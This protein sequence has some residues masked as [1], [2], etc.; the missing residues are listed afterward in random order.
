MSAS[1]F[2]TTNRRG[3][4]GAL[5][6]LGLQQLF[7]T[8]LV[9]QAPSPSDAW[10]DRMNGQHK[11][12]FDVPE[13]D[14][15]TALRH[16]HGYLDTWREAYGVAERDVN[17]VVGLYGRTTPWGVTDAM[18]D[19]YRLGAAIG[20]TDATTNAPPVRN[21][22]AHPKP[23]D[24]VGDGTPASSIEALQARGVT[25]LLCNNALQRWSGRLEHSGL[26]TAKDIHADLSAHALPGVV[27]VPNVMV[28][29]TKAHERG[30]TIVRS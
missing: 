24:P 3:F 6:A 23:G 5:A 22:F 10:L 28:S 4:V 14:G 2:L 15:G 29:M 16:G 20:L 18:W 11:M 19:K 8:E 21:W 7:A 26:G 17:L 13:P 25:F 27:I 9:A 12:F 1:T 30:F